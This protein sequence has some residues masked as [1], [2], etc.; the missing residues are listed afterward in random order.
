YSS[1]VYL[2][3]MI[4]SRLQLA[5]ETEQQASLAARRFKSAHAIARE[6]IMSILLGLAEDEKDYLAAGSAIGEQL[7]AMQDHTAALGQNLRY[8][9]EAD[10]LL[11]SLSRDISLIAED[12]SQAQEDTALASGKSE[13]ARLEYMDKQIRALGTADEFAQAKNQIPPSYRT[14]DLEQRWDSL[15]REETLL[16]QK[17]ADSARE[18]AEQTRLEYEQ[19]QLR[20]LNIRD[21]LATAKR[22]YDITYGQLRQ[23]F[24]NSEL[25]QQ[26]ASSAKKESARMKEQLEELM[27]D[28]SALL[29]QVLEG[30]ATPDGPEAYIETPEKASFDEA[31]QE[32]YAE[33]PDGALTGALSEAPDD[34]AGLSRKKVSAI[35]FLT[36]PDQTPDSTQQKTV[37]GWQLYAKTLLI[38]LAVF[39]IILMFI[40]Y[41]FIL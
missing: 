18:Q 25:E 26:W 4:Q 29:G 2:E 30:P 35:P 9:G 24:T 17:E 28:S 32:V 10:D 19:K 12:M 41:K 23:Y 37:T 1:A 39:V 14:F 3:A 34:D 36:Q 15:A 11:K 16:A 21:V 5:E 33:A 6:H 20:F 27:K 8:L 31:S 22:I 7:S 13:R 38:V 40:I